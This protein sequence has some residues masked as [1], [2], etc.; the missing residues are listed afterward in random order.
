[1]AGDP[2]RLHVALL[3]GGSYREFLCEAFR[4]RK[5]S[6]GSFSLAALATKVGCSAKSYPREVMTGRRALSADFAPRFAEAFGLRGDA[7]KL[8]LK[9]VVRERFPS[10]PAIEEEIRQL[11]D[12]LRCKAVRARAPS[13]VFTNTRWIDVY[14]ALG[15]LKR[16]ADF[17]EIGART[18]IIDSEL[19]TLLEAMLARR[20]VSCRE[21]R[22]FAGVP[23]R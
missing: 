2:G 14:A 7:R 10:Q 18:R 11:R 19:E 15:T 8:F 16:G 23:L 22:Y 13:D 1:M 5:A 17:N 4:Q 3:E 20:I 12:R 9:L 6:R 21:G